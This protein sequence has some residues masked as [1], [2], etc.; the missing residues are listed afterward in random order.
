MRKK[1]V[2]RGFINGGFLLNNNG[3][4]NVNISVIA[5]KN[6]ETGLCGGDC[7]LTDSAALSVLSYNAEASSCSGL[8]T[9]FEEL[10]IPAGVSTVGICDSLDFA[11]ASDS[12]PIYVN[13]S[14]PKDTT[15]GAKTLILTFESVAV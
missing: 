1:K 8:T 9:G 4:V 7:R 15:T 10:I 12:I 6:G 3:S 11:D 13:V 14:V 2:D 5:D